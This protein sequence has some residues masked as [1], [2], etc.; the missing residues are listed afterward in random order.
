LSDIENIKVMINTI[1]NIFFM[2]NLLF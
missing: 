2:I 1:E